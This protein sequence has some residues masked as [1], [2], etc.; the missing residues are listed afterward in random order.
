[1]VLLLLFEGF[2]CEKCF[3]QLQI[4]KKLYYQMEWKDG[5]IAEVKQDRH[6]NSR[7]KELRLNSF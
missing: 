5:I 4:T 7:A 1:M 6:V 3:S 2:R